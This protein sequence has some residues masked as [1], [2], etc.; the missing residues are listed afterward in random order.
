MFSNKKRPSSVSTEQ[1]QQEKKGWGGA[2]QD[3][4]EKKNNGWLHFAPWKKEKKNRR[5]SGWPCRAHR[6][7]VRG[8]VVSVPS[9]PLVLKK[10]HTRSHTTTSSHAH[11][12]TGT[13]LTVALT[14]R[15]ARPTRPR[16]S[17][18]A[19]LR[20]VEEPSWKRRPGRPAAPLSCTKTSY[21]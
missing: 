19:V 2:E 4:G 11:A 8:K 9:V 15:S 20:S 3:G 6:S 18:F 12:H 10:T 17:A 7:K 13:C 5:A 1:T 14:S 21:G 16:C